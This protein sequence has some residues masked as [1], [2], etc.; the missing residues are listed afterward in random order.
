MSK[1]NFIVF[2]VVAAIAVWL[3]GR[4]GFPSSQGGFYE[5]K[6]I[7]FI[8]VSSYILTAW[9]VSNFLPK[10]LKNDERLRDFSFKQVEEIEGCV[11]KTYSKFF[12]YKNTQDGDIQNE[13]LALFKQLSTLTTMFGKNPLFKPNQHK[14]LRM[15]YHHLKSK[16]T[17]DPFGTQEAYNNQILTEINKQYEN[18]LKSCQEIKLSLY[19]G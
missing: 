5:I 18:Y 13:V 4:F 14:N 16:I 15:C 9:I 1:Y 6:L 19:Q 8:R 12:A 2:L 3:Y 11:K 10:R 7:D 17:N